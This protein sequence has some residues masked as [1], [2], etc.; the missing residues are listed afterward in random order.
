MINPN[1]QESFEDILKYIGGQL[2]IEKPSA[3]YTMPSSYNK[4]QTSSKPKPPEK[5][6]YKIELTEYF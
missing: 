6:G 2:G 5:V 3:M 1:T 4:Q